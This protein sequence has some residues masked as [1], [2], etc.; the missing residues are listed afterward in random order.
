MGFKDAKTFQ[1]VNLRKIIAL[2]PFVD[3]IICC[4][5]FLHHASASLGSPVPTVVLWAGTNESHL[6]YKEQC[7]IHSWKKCEYEPNRIPHDHEYY[8]HKNKSSNEFKIEMIEE[9][10][11]NLN[12]NKLDKKE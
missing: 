6:G 5:S 3:G 12:I 11:N 10:I 8:I 7:N 1:N 2:I 9:V 4:D